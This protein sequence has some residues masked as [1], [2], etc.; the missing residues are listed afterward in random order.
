MERAKMNATFP[1]DDLRNTAKSS[2]RIIARTAP[3]EYLD[4]HNKF[5]VSPER[6]TVRDF[7]ATT[8]CKSEKQ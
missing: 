4:A 2:R 8:S 5:V 6:T 1:R 7:R 3:N